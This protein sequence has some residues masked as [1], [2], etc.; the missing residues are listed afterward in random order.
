MEEQAAQLL[1]TLRRPSASMDSKL[2]LFNTLKSG[3]KHQRVPEAAQPQIFECL[4]IAIGSQ[5]SSTLV[6]TGF[7]TLGHLIKRLTLQDQASTI[8]S[9]ATKFYPILLDRLGDA[10]ENHRSAAS[11]AFADLWPC[12]HAAV[13]NTIR[14]GALAGNSSRAREMAMQWVVKVRTANDTSWVV[15]T[16]G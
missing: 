5:T 6:S 8:A 1:A 15:L 11:Q 4:K 9:Q 13:E 2:Q 7:A 10:R 16:L 3:I 14:D 12:N